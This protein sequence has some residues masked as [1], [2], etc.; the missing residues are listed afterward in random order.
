MGY[1]IK[2]A[3]TKSI[4][5]FPKTAFNTLSKSVSLGYNTTSYLQTYYFPQFLFF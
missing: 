2:T 4:F 3:E 5:R 1:Y